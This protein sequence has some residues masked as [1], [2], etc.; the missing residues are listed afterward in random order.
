MW[1]RK[2]DAAFS[3]KSPG[4]G[5]YL[6]TTEWLQGW[7]DERNWS[8]IE[9]GKYQPPF[10]PL[11]LSSPFCVQVDRYVSQR[12]LGKF[13][14]VGWIKVLC[15]ISEGERVRV[16]LPILTD[17]AMRKAVSS[18]PHGMKIDQWWAKVFMSDSI[19]STAEGVAMPDFKSWGRHEHLRISK[20]AHSVVAK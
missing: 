4:D 11:Q 1:A 15:R 19:C 3:K 12:Y 17:D 10:P 16:I 14:H 9:N 6:V 8:T 20:S 2:W 18:P 7:F 13:K 5:A